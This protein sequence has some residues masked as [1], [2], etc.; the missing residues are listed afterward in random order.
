MHGADE[1]GPE[2][3]L[4]T[5]FIP[6][7]LSKQPLPEIGEPTLVIHPPMLIRDIRPCVNHGVAEEA[8]YRQFP[9]IGHS[10]DDPVSEYMEWHFPQDLEPPYT[11]PTSACKTNLKRVTVLLSWLHQLSVKTDR[12]QGL[13]F[14]ELLHWLW[15][16]S[17]FT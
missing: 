7:S 10:F 11:I 6:E 4:G 15:W 17:A 16:K 1:E 14:R 2:E 13:P 5:Y 9:G 12:R 3:Q 8:I